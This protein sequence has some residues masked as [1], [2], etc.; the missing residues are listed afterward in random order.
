[1]HQGLD[2]KVNTDAKKGR[3]WEALSGPGGSMLPRK[4]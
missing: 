4:F 2:P 3:Y 1:M